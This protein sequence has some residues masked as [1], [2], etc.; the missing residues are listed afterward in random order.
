MRLYTACAGGCRILT[1]NANNEQEA[2]EALSTLLGTTGGMSVRAASPGE[3]VCWNSS[4]AEAMRA[5]REQ[6]EREAPP[7]CTT[8]RLLPSGRMRSR[9]DFASHKP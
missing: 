8:A 9:G 1:I 3:M 2:W 7:A 4:A 6:P 5:G